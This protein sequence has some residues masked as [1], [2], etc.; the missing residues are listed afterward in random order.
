MVYCLYAEVGGAA[1][2]ERFRYLERKRNR[3]SMEFMERELHSGAL[4]V[5]GA[6][7]L[8]LSFESNNKF[9]K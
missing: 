2:L 4:E 8:T 1:L 6:P 5:L 7:G 3:R 9:I